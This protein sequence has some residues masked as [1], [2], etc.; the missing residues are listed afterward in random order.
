MNEILL[1]VL[2]VVITAIVLPLISFLGFKL[3]QFLNS[4]I[5]DEK[6]KKLLDKANEIVLDAV[7]IVFQ[8][9]VE[10]LKEKNEF[11]KSAQSIA[12]GKAKR[13]V[14]SELNDEIKSFISENYGDLSIWITNQIE[15]SIYKLKN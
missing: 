6:T 15:A 12:L 13:I 9:Y 1:N 8:T 3:S 7:R 5:K 11:D 4:K 10:A 2:S 14:E